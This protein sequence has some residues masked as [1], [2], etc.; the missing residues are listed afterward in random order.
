MILRTS[1][2]AL[3]VLAALSVLAGCAGQSKNQAE[4]AAAAKPEPVAAA[5]APAPTKP[6]VPSTGKTTYEQVLK[7]VRG[8]RGDE[9]KLDKALVGKD[10]SARIAKVKGAGDDFAVRPADP[11]RFRCDEGE[12]FAGGQVSSRIVGVDWSADTKRALLQLDRCG[13][14]PAVAAA[15]APKAAPAAAPAAAAAAPAAA[16]A[17]RAGASAKPG[18]DAQGNVIDS[19]KIEAGSGRTVKGMNDYEGEITGNPAPNS[20]FTQLQ[21]GMSLKQVTDIA[22][23]PTDS[24]AYVTGKAFI[25]FYFGGD[26]TR[27]ELAYKGQ[28]RLIFAGGNLGNISGGN[29]VWII[30]NAT[31]T[32]YR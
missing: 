13:P 31:D 15:P 3:A 10:L 20:K 32:G 4:P 1:S 22:G 17:G 23:Q 24:G 9:A 6:E 7:M 8:A 2:T 14:A 12:S 26:R 11:V 28:G 21:I 29:L 19:S 16:P 30:H 18:M 27:I 5:P 25:P